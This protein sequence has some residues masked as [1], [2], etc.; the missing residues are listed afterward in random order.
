MLIWLIFIDYLFYFV[1]LFVYLFVL[2]G[3]FLYLDFFFRIIKLYL[4]KFN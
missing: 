1:D 4:I 3:N 2:F